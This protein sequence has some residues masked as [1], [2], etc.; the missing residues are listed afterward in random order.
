MTVCNTWSNPDFTVRTGATYRLIA[1]LNAI[2]SGL[3][4]VDSQS[5]SGNPGSPHYRDQL[6]EWVAGRYHFLP[7]D[8]AEVSKVAVTQVGLAPQ[9][10]T[11][12]GSHG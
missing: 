1:D 3:W 11:N 9:Q 10:R 6:T 2:P 8:A 4:A 12:H 5:Q 7:L